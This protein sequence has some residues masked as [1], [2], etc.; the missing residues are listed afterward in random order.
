MSDS[1]PPSVSPKERLIL[2]LLT[3]ARTPLYGLE[4]V[5]RSDE[6][7][8]RGAVYVMLG[9]MSEKGLV[10]SEVEPPDPTRSGLP[11]RRYRVTGL[12]QRVLAAER[13][14]DGGVRTGSLRPVFG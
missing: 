7:I 14:R 1:L 4:L 5:R 9:R 12:G 6:A 11:R 13:S 3:R 2:E 8:T 10:D